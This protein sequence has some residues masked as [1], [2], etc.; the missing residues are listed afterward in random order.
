MASP[1]FGDGSVVRHGKEGLEKGSAE[2]A[3]PGGSLF[4][5]RN[6]QRSRSQTLGRRGWESFPRMRLPVPLPGSENLPWRA[7]LEAFA[8]P[9]FGEPQPGC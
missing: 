2:P 1:A 7:S 6:S 3:E 4:P 5:K 8:P 9:W